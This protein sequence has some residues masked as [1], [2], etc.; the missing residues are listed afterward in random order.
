MSAQKVVEDII[1]RMVWHA[2]KAF[3]E[4]TDNLVLA[5]GVALNC[6][7]NGK[8]K[9]SGVF[10]HMW[11]QPATG[12][13]GGSLGALLYASYQYAGIERIIEKRIYK[14]AVISGLSIHQIRFK[15][16]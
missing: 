13:A 14:R 4:G 2:K 6:V 15:S 5:G 9:N 8:I 12:D 11:I 10:K 3:G 16:I 7:A 1:L